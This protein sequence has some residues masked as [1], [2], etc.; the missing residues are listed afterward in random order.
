M[1]Q[2]MLIFE[3][4]VLDEYILDSITDKLYGYKNLI[5]DESYNGYVVKNIKNGHRSIKYKSIEDI[6]NVVLNLLN[7]GY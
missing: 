6:P 1:N 4:A 7:R 5:I 3:N 2:M